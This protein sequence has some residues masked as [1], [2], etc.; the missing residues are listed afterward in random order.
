MQEN[1]STKYKVKALTVFERN[2]KKLAKKHPS[3]H[4]D[5]SELLQTLEENPAQGIALGNNSYKIRMKISSKSKGKSGGARLISHI[6]VHNETVY[7]L[8]I[9]DKSKQENISEKEIL[10]LI[11]MI[12][13]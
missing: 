3:I 13:E 1:C 10:R 12:D 8:T 9:Y 2:L 6:V 7:L 4:Q 5:F 11:E